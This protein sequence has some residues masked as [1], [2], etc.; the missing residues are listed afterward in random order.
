MH[1]PIIDTH[2][3]IWDLHRAAYPWLAGD[4]SILNRTYSLHE[5]EEE[6]EKSNV[7]AGILVQAAGNSED[8]A[9][10]LEAAKETDW[11][12]GV[13]GWLPLMEP[14]AT[15]KLLEQQYSQERYFAGVRH[16]VHDESDV[17]W[18][19]QAPVVESLR[20]IAAHG[21]PYDMVG[22]L[23]AHIETALKLA[24]KLP[25]LRIVFDHLNQP[26]IAAR[27]KFGQWGE[28]M[29]TAA[30]HPLFYAKISG[31]GTASGNF[32]G[33]T[34]ADLQPYIEY[35]LS[36]FGTNRCFC[37]GDWPVSLLATGYA[38]TWQT[39]EEVLSG[40]LPEKEKEKVLYSNAVNFYGL[41]MNG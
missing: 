14:A 41:E 3:H 37:G 20:I 21:L 13:V 23:P 25:D 27:E 34:A 35:V 5:L 9:L 32:K 1:Q 6:R 38:N 2:I 10:M 11:I 19:L 31:L 17:N 15:K 26:P 29:K 28:L 16:Q 40:L 36:L 24:E 33:R 39:Y 18:L 7:T 12:K 30:Q 4:T 22:I 8:T